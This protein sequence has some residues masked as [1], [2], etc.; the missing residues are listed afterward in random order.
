MLNCHGR[1]I[2]VALLALL[3]AIMLAGCA[4][5]ALPTLVATVDPPP[6]ATP[7][8][9]EPTTTPEIITVP[10]GAPGSAAIT[11]PGGQSS[12]QVV[13]QGAGSGAALPAEVQRLLDELASGAIL[14]NSAPAGQDGQPVNYAY[15]D[16]NGDGI[17]D[18]VVIVVAEPLDQGGGEA[19]QPVAE[20]AQALG[21]NLD[22]LVESIS[23]NP[24]APLIG[25]A[26]IYTMNQGELDELDQP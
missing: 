12:A 5:D 6:E 4:G 16:L 7:R 1:N 23:Q 2:L 9:P 21:I 17:R 18:L 24:E 22:A 13:I 3:V 8:P 15:R 20:P 10:A 11:L 26:F 14:L 19:G 25:S